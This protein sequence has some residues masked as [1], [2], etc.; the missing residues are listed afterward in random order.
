MKKRILIPLTLIALGIAVLFRPL[1]PTSEWMQKTSGIVLPQPISDLVVREDHEVYKSLYCRIPKEAV[2]DFV[3][4][5]GYFDSAPRNFQSIDFEGLPRDYTGFNDLVYMTGAS[6]YNAWDSVLCRSTG[7]LWLAVLC[8]D[9]AG[10]LP[11]RAL[12]SR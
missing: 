9:F 8:P 2:S 3:R 4:E 10:D 12:K 7:E 1:E 6:D 5:F 11:P